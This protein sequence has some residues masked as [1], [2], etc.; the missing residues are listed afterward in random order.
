MYSKD[1]RNIAIDLY[2]RFKNYRKVAN[3]LKISTSTIH[4]WVNT[5]V[6]IVKKREF[7]PRKFF[8]NIIN[9]IRKF[10][11][12][13]PIC[14]LNCIRKHL[15]CECNLITT[16]KSISKTLKRC[17]ITKKKAYFK[18]LAKDDT[19]ET[20]FIE[21]YNKI[22]KNQEIVSIDECYFS[23]NVLPN[24][25]YTDKGKRLY[26]KR[27]QLGKRKN[28]S[29]LLAISNTGKKKY[30]I[31][32]GAV[33]SLR[34]KYFI[35][36][37]NFS[38]NSIFLIDNVPFHKSKIIKHAFN[39]KKYNMLFTPPY[40]PKYNPVEHIFFKIKNNFRKLNYHGIDCIS[41]I[42]NSIHSVTKTDIINCFIH[43]NR[44]K[45]NLIFRVKGND[46]KEKEK[47]DKQ[48]YK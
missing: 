48:T 18:N 17:N 40:E 26:I 44:I 4:N 27:N 1:F 20:Q 41:A 6:Q 13:M 23:E 31:F 9:E 11:I 10:V 21:D 34:F 32:D 12:Q 33:N 29:L 37:C 16:N 42:T 39:N 38:N 46:Q 47:R 2:N 28:R 35:E 3:L 19:K 43:L 7:K 22:N 5:T 14:T 25:G 45:K 30:C 24:Y 15:K 8:D 36:K